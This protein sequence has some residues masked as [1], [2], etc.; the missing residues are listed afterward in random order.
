M[1]IHSLNPFNFIQVLSIMQSYSHF[2]T[3]TVLAGLIGLTTIGCTSSPTATMP[4]SSKRAPIVAAN[5]PSDRATIAPQAEASQPIANNTTTAPPKV[6]T[7]ESGTTSITRE[8]A[9][10]Q[11]AELPE[12]DAWQEY[13]NQRTAGKV[14]TALIV[15]PET[16]KT[17]AGQ[18]YWSVSFYESEATHNSRWQTFLVR[19]DGQEILV[20]DL[21]GNYR[22][23]ENWRQQDKPMA[24]VGPPTIES[25]P[26]KQLPFVGT[27]RFNFLNGSGTGQSITIDPDGTTTVKT[28]GTMNTSVSYSGPF[29]NPIIFKDGDGVKLEGDTIYSLRTDGTIAEGCIRADEPCKS[30]LN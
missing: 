7:V 30:E 25:A 11:V 20:D 1:T 6:K 3:I 27:K 21:E 19:V 12:I 14:L 23:L 9:I 26:E 15:N 13:V 29:T 2:F 17:Y 18:E 8:Q 10:A 5:E 16:P 28:H 22:S 24:R 4:P